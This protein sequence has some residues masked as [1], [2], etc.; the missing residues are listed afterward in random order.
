V[1]QTGLPLALEST[2]VDGGRP[3]DRTRLAAARRVR[4]TPELAGAFLA[5]GAAAQNNLA[6]LLEGA[7][8]VTTGQQ[9]G[10][11]TGP[12]YTIHKALTA[13]ALAERA[14]LELGE[15][16]VPVFWVAGDD[17]D[18]A[19]ANHAHVLGRAN[20]VVT[21]VLRERDAAATLEPLYREPVG[22]EIARV[23]D[24]LRAALPETEFVAGVLA[25]LE[26]HYRPET[27]LASAFSHAVAELLGPF[28]LVVL[29]P[30][31][32]AFKRAMGPWIQRLLEAAPVLHQALV[33]ES[34]RLTERGG[35]AQV[36]VGEPA[37]L[38]MIEGSLGRDR[39][40]L[41]GTAYVARRSGERWSA[42]ELDRMVQAEPER[43]SPNVL[44]RPAIE[45]ALLPTIAYVGGPAELNYWLQAQP[46]YRTLEVP[47]QA[48]VPRWS[49]RVIEAR[50]AKVLQKYAIT[51][52]ALTQPEGQLE[53][54]LVAAT[55][56][57][58]ARE[59]LTGL[60]AALAAEY[61]KLLAAAVAVDPTL[62][63][64]VESAQHQ[65]LVAV[66]EIEKRLLSHLKKQNAIVLEQ[67]A[68]A[69]RN[70]F[71]LGRPQERVFTVGTYL[72]R[73]GEAFLERVLAACRQHVAS[74][75]PVLLSA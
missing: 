51:P 20:E 62:R 57:P 5:R 35:T 9:P 34:G 4:L 21:L 16:V 36:S 63:K 74:L 12:L 1:T 72:A 22:P 44:A 73:Y 31:H 26:R 32:R 67:I 70:L 45:A 40:L 3:G 52:E 7:L 55:L 69:R 18:F 29:Q 39:L 75:D 25:W 49:G 53:A 43:F 58:E 8:C 17:H 61:G 54:A 19:E 56:P 37:T 64:P 6:R 2:P 66:Q 68:K 71:P 15:P 65:A 30:T 50:I 13:V 14:S 27:D 59:A 11:L 48:G 33:A 28:G 41:D 46:V 60:R 42:A 24:T 10:L 23:W 38:V 47:A